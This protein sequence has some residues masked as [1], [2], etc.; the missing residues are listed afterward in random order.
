MAQLLLGCSLKLYRLSLFLLAPHHKC[1]ITLRPA[2]AVLKCQG[3]MGLRNLKSKLKRH[4]H[5]SAPDAGPPETKDATHGTITVQ[6]IVV[7]SKLE[8]NK[9]ASP[10]VPSLPDETLTPVVAEQRLAASASDNTSI[11]DLWDSAYEKLREDEPTVEEYEEKLRV[12]LGVGRDSKL[13]T[14]TGGRRELMGMILQRKMDEVNSKAWKLRFGNTEVLVKDSVQPVLGIISRV[15]D[16]VACTLGPTP[17]ASIAWAGISLLLPVYANTRANPLMLYLAGS[18]VLSQLLTNP[19]EQATSLAKGLEYISGVVAQS[20]MWEELYVRRYESDSSSKPWSS[21]APFA[22]ESHIE[23]KSAL[24]MLY[25]EV[26]R[27]Q[28]TSYCYYSRSLASRLTLDIIKW[29][30]WTQLLED[31]REKERVFNAISETWRDKIFDEECAAAERRHK[32]ALVCWKAVGTELTELRRAVVDA[33]KESTRAT[34]LDWLCDIDVSEMYNSGRDKHG[35]GTGAWL[36]EEHEDFR[37]WENKPAS[38]LWLH[39]KSK[40]LDPC[41]PCQICSLTGPLSRLWEIDFDLVN[42]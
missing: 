22:L 35:T 40:H 29:N 1:K 14:D 25:V 37:F 3:K 23:Y 10:P 17:S 18:D 19:S 9:E 5:G 39:G 12:D 16:Y 27:F 24:A 30:D 4:F 33:Q 32:E 7:H 41:Y 15:N 2:A 21:V 13:G 6:E 11:V 42:H 26:L 34:L 28:I 31:V 38:F 20:R 8:D 36:I